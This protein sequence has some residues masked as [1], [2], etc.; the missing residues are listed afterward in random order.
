MYILNIIYND[1][2][3]VGDVWNRVL[4]RFKVN[5][6]EHWSIDKK[7]RVSYMIER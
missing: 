2:E 1:L 4:L 3:D 7:I 5:K 6:T